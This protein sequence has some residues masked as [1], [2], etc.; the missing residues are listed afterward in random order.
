MVTTLAGQNYDLQ[1]SP[2]NIALYLI[3]D[4]WNLTTDGYIPAKSEISFNTFGWSGRKS[5]QLSVEPFTPPAL[6][7][8]NIGR[9]QLTQYR[10][11]LLL[12]VYMIKN[13][14]EVPP[15][16]HHITQKAEQIVRDN[17]ANVGYGITGIRLT[18][19]FSTVETMTAYTGNFPNQVEVS[20]WHSR[21]VVELLYYRATT[22]TLNGVRISKTHKY[23][24]E[25][26]A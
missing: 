8:L 23:N 20:L 15:Q 10:D 2:E 1:D 18:S 25:E 24:V 19:P 21:A 7:E 9:E 12:H 16:L 13:R 26:S 4:R 3:R 22:G 5:Y 17:I 14:D 6:L 11:Q